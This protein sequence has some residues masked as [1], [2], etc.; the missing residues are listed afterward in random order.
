MRK[1]R[2]PWARRGETLFSREND[3]QTEVLFSKE[4]DISTATNGTTF[5]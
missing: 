3:P 5:L 4:K 2:Q 1:E